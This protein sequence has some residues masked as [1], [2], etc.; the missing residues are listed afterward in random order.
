MTVEWVSPTLTGGTLLLKNYGQIAGFF[1]GIWDI[2]TKKKTELAI[3]GMEGVGKSVLFDNLTGKAFT[4]RYVKPRKS[5]T[6]EHGAIRSMQRIRA[7]VVPGQPAYPRY[8]AL[9]NLFTTGKRVDGVIHVVSGGLP[10]IREEDRRA[11]LVEQKLTTIAEFRKFYKGFELKDLRETCE[12]IRIAHRKRHAP[13]WLIVAVDKIDLFHDT[14][15]DEQRHY[16]PDRGS[17]FAQVLDALS[18]DV[19]KHNFRWTAIPVC[20][21][22][23][24][25]EWNGQRLATKISEETRKAYFAQFLSELEAF[26]HK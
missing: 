15:L 17:Q 9:D 21:R 4:E 2:I 18:E 26:C 19:G 20:G 23:E 3:T 5:Q 12:S 6:L 16:S 10:F 1:K 24:P 11:L 8:E 7:S 13:K 22:C 14:I 25:F